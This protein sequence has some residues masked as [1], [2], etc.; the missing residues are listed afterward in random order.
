MVC[1]SPLKIDRIRFEQQSCSPDG[2]MTREMNDR[3]GLILFVRCKVEV[4]GPQWSLCDDQERN[5]RCQ[6]DKLHLENPRIYA[7]SPPGRNIL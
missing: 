1:V 7:A 3:S 2:F 5:A 4:T 6:H